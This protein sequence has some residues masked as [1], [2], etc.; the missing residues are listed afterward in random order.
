MSFA[1]N[2]AQTAE[3]GKLIEDH[4]KTGEYVLSEMECMTKE[5][6]YF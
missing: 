4:I 2:D 5:L 3:A 1:L 6:E